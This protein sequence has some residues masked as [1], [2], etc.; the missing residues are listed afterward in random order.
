VLNRRQQRFIESYVLRGTETLD[1]LISGPQSGEPTAL[2]TVSK[3]SASCRIMVEPVP[4]RGSWNMAVDEALLEAAAN[5]R[6]CALRWYRWSEATISLGY[7]QRLDE[8]AGFD[9]LAALPVVRRLSGGG[10]ILHHHEWTY[11]CAIPSGHWLGRLH[12]EAYYELVHNRII[13]VLTRHG[14]PIRMRGATTDSPDAAFLCFGRGDARDLVVGGHKILGSA[15]RRRRGAVIQHGSLL[16]KASHYAPQFPGITDLVPG[17]AVDDGLIAELA[18]EVGRLLVE[19]SGDAVHLE[20]S[21]LAEDRELA[22]EFERRKYL[23]ADWNGI[24]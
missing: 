8:A 18:V 24:R 14:V 3:S 6:Q 21:L 20:S 16:L 2:V 13:A 7:F 10:A 4:S 9:K 5:R 1:E 19:P 17:F 12:H 22:E 23:E 15:Q 11:A